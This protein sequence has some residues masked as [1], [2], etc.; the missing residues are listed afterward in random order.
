MGGLVEVGAHQSRGGVYG[1]LGI[2]GSCA[3][4]LGHYPL[5]AV[6]LSGLDSGRNFINHNQLN[7]GMHPGLGKAFLEYTEEDVAYGPVR[8]HNSTQGQS[9]LAMFEARYAEKRIELSDGLRVEGLIPGPFMDKLGTRSPTP[10]L[11]SLRYVQESPPNFPIRDADG[12]IVHENHNFRLGL[13]FSELCAPVYYFVRTGILL[14]RT[15][16]AWNHAAE[17]GHRFQ[18]GACAPMQRRDKPSKANLNRST[19]SD[20]RRIP[21]ESAHDSRVTSLLYP[22]NGPCDCGPAFVLEPHSMPLERTGSSSE[23]E[24]GIRVG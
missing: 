3:H 13:S 8:D 12:N 14:L 19:C 11:T 6:Y 15:H 17:M 24:M 9:E 5:R 20:T 16:E 1:T 2:P 10:Y 4:R 23:K 7:R 21:R 22:Q 18:H